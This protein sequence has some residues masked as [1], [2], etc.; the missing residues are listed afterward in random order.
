LLLQK[1]IAWLAVTSYAPVKRVRYL[2]LRN[3]RVLLFF[4]EPSTL[5]FLSVGAGN[6]IG[7]GERFLKKVRT[8][9]TEGKTIGLLTSLLCLFARRQVVSASFVEHSGVLVSQ[10]IF[11]KK[12][13]LRQMGVR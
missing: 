9:A 3:G 6:H 5:Y 11:K 10:R 12:L 7:V 1:K 4:S 2:A 8:T 13:T